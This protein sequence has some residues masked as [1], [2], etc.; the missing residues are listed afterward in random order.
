MIVPCMLR[1]CY[2]VTALALFLLFG[3]YGYV[4]AHVALPHQAI[5]TSTSGL[6]A[7]G[8]NGGNI[9]CGGGVGTHC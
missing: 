3:G 9:A 6:L 2:A 5:V 4:A 8:G 7:D 1:R